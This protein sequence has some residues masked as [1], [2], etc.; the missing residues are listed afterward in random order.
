MDDLGIA[1]EIA[2][3]KNALT[4]VNLKAR[5]SSRGTVTLT[6]SHPQDQLN[7]Q[8]QHF[9]ADGGLADVA[10]L[11]EGI[12]TVRSL[13]QGS[14]GI[15]IH[16]EEEVFPGPQANTDDEIDAHVYENIFGGMI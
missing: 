4:A 14:L 5:T 9:Q 3:Y 10:A 15:S 12:K 16:I 11:R 7:I 1:Q 8:K 6:G 13:A 2:V